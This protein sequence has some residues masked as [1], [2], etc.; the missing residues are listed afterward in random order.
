VL[1]PHVSAYS[2][3]LTVLPA[4]NRRDLSSP[5]ELRSPPRSA[6]PAET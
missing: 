5:V 1:V 2:E 4:A 3:L 6:T